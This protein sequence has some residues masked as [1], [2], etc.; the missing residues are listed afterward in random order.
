MQD[1]ACWFWHR[2]RKSECKTC[3]HPGGDCTGENGVTASSFCMMLHFYLSLV[4]TCTVWTLALLYSVMQF[5]PSLSSS[6]LPTAL[7][8]WIAGLL[9]LCPWQRDNQNFRC[10]LVV[11]CKD[12]CSIEYCYRTCELSDSEFG[13]LHAM[14]LDCAQLGFPLHDSLPFL[15]STMSTKDWCTSALAL[16]SVMQGCLVG[17]ASWIFLTSWCAP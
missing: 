4:R 12:S 14:M 11:P 7:Q 8:P 16:P 5:G 2:V 1:E 6:N 17:R 13:Y 15:G 10:S 9:V 3:L